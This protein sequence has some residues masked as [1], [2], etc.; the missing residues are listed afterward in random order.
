MAMKP[1][2]T[3][4]VL[5]A[6]LLLAG[7][8]ASAAEDKP[9]LRTFRRGTTESYRV[10]LTLKSEVHGVATETIGAKT[11]VTPYMHS[12]EAT[13]AW[14]VT[15]QVL[16]TTAGGAK[17]EEALSTTLVRCAG[18]PEAQSFDPQLQSSLEEL[19]LQWTDPAVLTYEENRQGLISNL[20]NQQEPKLAESSPALLSLWLR[21]ALR[22]SVIFPPAPFRVGAKDERKISPAAAGLAGSSGS[23]STEWL[24]SPGETP[25]S[26]L[27][28]S[29]QLAWTEPGEAGTTG[30]AQPAGQAS[31][32]AD[33]MTTVS[34]VDG[35]VESATRSASRELRRVL[36]P[37]E[38]LAA[39]PEFRTRLMAVV[40]LRR[41][42]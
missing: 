36:D 4:P 8:G 22:P 34:L 11:Y 25:A 7:F 26:I 23:E 41:R 42:S 5:A 2:A 29:Q 21:R 1:S 14:D 20:S 6:M 27:H 32:Y 31:F 37:V 17:L 28:V 3:Q 16:D 19:C 38:G 12:A 24:L 39:P 15:R 35:S 13:L 40:T 33:S 18:H 9:F 10:E 30:R